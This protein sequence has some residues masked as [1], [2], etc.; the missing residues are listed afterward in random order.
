LKSVTDNAVLNGSTPPTGASFVEPECPANPPSAGGM[1]ISYVVYL[2]FYQDF[3]FNM[4]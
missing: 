1:S 2:F 4:S 3:D